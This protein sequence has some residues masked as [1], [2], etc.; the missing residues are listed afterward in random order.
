MTECRTLA[1][2][3]EVERALRMAAELMEGA[4]RGR[5]ANL[6]AVALMCTGEIEVLGG[7]PKEARIALEEAK[8]VARGAET[9]LN[10]EARILFWLAWAYLGEGAQAEALAA[11]QEA[12]AIA[13]L[14]GAR[15]HEAAAHVVRADVLLATSGL[16]RLAEIEYAHRQAAELIEQTDAGIVTPDLHSSLARKAELRGDPPA[17]KRALESARESLERMGA[18][19]RAAQVA[20]E[21]A[22]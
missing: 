1:H 17:R 9:M 14:R 18:R 16:D 7:R 20:R 22:S 2:Q 4:Q 3:G 8:S 13:R 19:S 15:H 11:S 10:L 12:I 5:N 6:I 21:L